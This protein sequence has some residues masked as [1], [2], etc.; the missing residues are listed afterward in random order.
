MAIENPINARL[1]IVD[2]FLIKFNS[3]D[4]HIHNTTREYK[5]RTNM[6]TIVMVCNWLIESHEALG[7]DHGFL[8]SNEEEIAE[9]DSVSIISKLNIIINL[10]S[11]SL[12]G[13]DETLTNL[14]F[15]ALG[16][17]PIDQNCN[18]EEVGTMEI[19]VSSAIRK[20]LYFTCRK[21]ET[22]DGNVWA[23]ENLCTDEIELLDKMVFLLHRNNHH[24]NH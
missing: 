21:V 16:V 7:T 18:W 24:Q 22:V 5:S 13:E 3:S 17:L 9:R 12:S 2:S 4:S 20:K 6:E 11:E 15:N 1:S 23:L 10:M 8:R 14:R 19:I